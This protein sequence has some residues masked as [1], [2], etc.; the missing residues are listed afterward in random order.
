MPSS[1]ILSVTPP[2]AT[3][4]GRVS[5][6]GSD[7]PIRDGVPIVHVGNEP[8]RVVFASSSELALIVPDAA[9]GAERISAEGSDGSAVLQVGTSVATGLHQVDS[10]AVDPFGT[11]YLTYSGTRGQEVP[12]SIFRVPR[13]GA[14]ESFSSGVTNPTGMAVGPDGR[15]YVSSRFEG[16]VYRLSED[17]SAEV[18]ASDLGIACGLAFRADGTLFVG[19]R[20][21]TLFAVSPDGQARTF[22]TLP[23]SVAAFHL[24]FGPDGLY[25]TAPTLSARDVVYRIDDEGGTSVVYAGFGRPQGLAFSPD[26]ELHVVEA[27]AGV[28]GVYRVREGEAPELIVAGP[29]LVGLAFDEDDLIVCSSD[30]AYRI[31]RRA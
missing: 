20:S 12:V 9:T 19:D 30:T 31:P 24:A 10:P 3:P 7:F 4:G 14:R 25:V 5:I 16:S 11:I 27:L 28:S 29:R 23:S 15:L 1:R 13:G 18:Y 2:R 8:A 6:L 21:G 17:G 26:G 22:A